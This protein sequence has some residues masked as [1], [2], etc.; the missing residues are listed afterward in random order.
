[1]KRI[2]IITPCILPVPSTTGGAVEGLITRIISDNEIYRNY[3]I[4]LYTISGAEDCSNNYSYTDFILVKLK[5]HIQISDRL[6]DK[7]YRTAHFNSAGRFLDREITKVFLER[8]FKI[9]GGYDFVII[10]NM[11]STACEIVNLCNGKYDFPLYFHMHNDVDMYRSPGQI[12]ELVRYGVQF[13]AV[14]DY[15]KGQILKCA[16]NAVVHTLYNGIDMSRYSRTNCSGSDD[17]LTF[18]YAGR[19]ITD[20]GVKELLTAFVGANRR[21]C[22]A[23]KE[24]G[25]KIKLDIV[26]FSGFDR[27]YEKEIRSIAAGHE[28]IRCIKWIHADKMPLLFKKADVVVMPS[29]VEEAFGLCAL[30]AMAEGIPLITSNSGAL[31]EIVGDGALV[32]DKKGD[33][34]SNLSEAIESVIYDDSLRVELS[35]RAFDRAHGISAFNLDNYYKGFAE[36]NDEQVITE[37][38][39]ISVIIPVYNVE[40]YIRRCLSSVMD[41][42]YRNLEIILVDDGSTDDSGNIC[43]VTASS[44][45]RII[46]IHQD[47]KGLSEARNT[48][49]DNATGRFIFFCD[50]DDSLMPDALEKMLLRLKRDH[51]DVVACGYENVYEENEAERRVTATDLRPG[52]WSGRQSVIQMMRGNNVCSVAWNKLYKKTL[53][54]GIRFPIG[55]RNEDEATVYKCL[56]KAGIVSYMPDP[57]YNYYQRAESIMHEDLIDRY[58]FSMQALIQRCRFFA[59]CKDNELEQHS[60]ISL[61]EWI[62]YSY[63]NI[64]DKEIRKKLVKIYQEN[65]TVFNAPTVMEKKK[66]LALLIWKYFRY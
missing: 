3:C 44:D 61:L 55:V 42:T 65:I 19:I 38:D 20:K 11:A 45:D 54:D 14:S 21:M 24:D 22:D 66:Q 12:R 56:Y 28:N 64:E 53:F 50:S 26:G 5:K 10:E 37:E 2:A 58:E 35:G 18:L 51:A 40:R 32:A 36:I 8:L 17:E 30:E 9:E 34:I 1:M 7:Y 41:Q 39:K 31:P 48:G 23:E 15:I 6:L 60:R 46:V 16:A 49:L 29:L 4:D 52:R 63:R 27:A 13:L 47:N 43:D 59:D 62:K 25:K 33:F 57:L